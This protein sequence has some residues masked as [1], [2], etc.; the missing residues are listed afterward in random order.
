M[1]G[2]S[3]CGVGVVWF[4]GESGLIGGVKNFSGRGTGSVD[5]GDNL[6]SHSGTQ[7]SAMLLSEGEDGDAVMA[8]VGH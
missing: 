2:E 4:A 8:G 7:I 6:S 1:G 5:K 3:A